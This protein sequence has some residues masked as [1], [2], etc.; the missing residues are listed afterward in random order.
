MNRPRAAVIGVLLGLSLVLTSC[1]LPTTSGTSKTTK[2]TKNKAVLVPFGSSTSDSTDSHD[3]TNGIVSI[4]DTDP[5]DTTQPAVI[6]AAAIDTTPA[7]TDVSQNPI[8]KS[9]NRVVALN[10]RIDKGI[11][12]AVGYTHASTLVRAVKALPVSD[13]RNAYDD[14]SA[15]LTVARRRR[16][17]MVRDFMIDVG[18]A[19]VRAT[20]LQVLSEAIVKYESDPR[21][22]TAAA[23]N[24]V[25]SKY[26]NTKCGFALTMI[27][28]STKQ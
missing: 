23:N 17:A 6:E 12:K 20:N 8:C 14:L 18:M 4:P 5:P 1:Q 28:D 22:A 25:L 3:P 26:M 11:T 16:L 9:A 2:T 21:A 13:L 15:V 7:T 19:L 27:G 10:E 24:K